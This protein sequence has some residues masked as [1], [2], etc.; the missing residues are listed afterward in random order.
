V[1]IAR[2]VCFRINH[3][4]L[5]V[6]HVIQ[7]SFLWT[8]AQGVSN[9]WLEASPQNLVQAP[10]IFVRLGHIQSTVL[11]SA[12]IVVQVLFLQEE[13]LRVACV[14]LV[15]SRIYLDYRHAHLV[16]KVSLLPQPTARRV[17]H[18]LLV[19]LVTLLAKVTASSVLQEVKQ[20]QM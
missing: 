12:N 14:L 4:R 8:E 5:A 16:P 1:V 15:L 10:A 13:I 7:G 18:A 20:D 6:I 19:L 11:R 3:K 9:V 17:L 2:E